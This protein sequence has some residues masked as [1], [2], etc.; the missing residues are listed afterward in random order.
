MNPWNL[1]YGYMLTRWRSSSSTTNS[2]KKTA[3]IWSLENCENDNWK[4]IQNN[5]PIYPNQKIFSQV[6]FNSNLIINYKNMINEK[7]PLIPEI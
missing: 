6:C 3:K 2:C 7:N 5:I 1:W 4:I